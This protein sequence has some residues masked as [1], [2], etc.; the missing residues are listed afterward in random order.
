MKDFVVVFERTA[1]P[2]DSPEFA[3]SLKR[4]AAYHDLPLVEELS[5]GWLA[6]LDS[7]PERAALP[8]GSC[9]LLITN[10]EAFRPA[11]CGQFFTELEVAQ[12][13]ARQLGVPAPQL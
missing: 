2:N 11:I 3:A 12:F 5:S 6:I 1:G 9:P 13:A 10:G 8:S 7:R 4:E